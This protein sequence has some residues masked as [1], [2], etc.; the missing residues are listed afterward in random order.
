[1]NYISTD[2]LLH[3]HLDEPVKIQVEQSDED[4]LWIVG[5]VSVAGEEFCI[6]GINRI[7]GRQL[8]P[9]QLQLHQPGL[10]QEQKLVE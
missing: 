3:N 1:M 9:G 8:F 5:L 7:C 4:G 10:L 6:G 2:N